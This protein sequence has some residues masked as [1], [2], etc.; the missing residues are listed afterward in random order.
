MWYQYTSTTKHMQKTLDFMKDVSSGG[1]MGTLFIIE[2]TQGN[3][4]DLDGLTYFPEESEAILAMLSRFRV[5]SRIVR[6]DMNV[7]LFSLLEIPMT[8]VIVPFST[9]VT[10]SSQ[11]A[12]EIALAQL[13]DRIQ[14]LE[15][16][17]N[18]ELERVRQEKDHVIAEKDNEIAQVIAEKDHIIA[19]TIAEKEAEKEAAVARAVQEAVEKEKKVASEREKRL[20]EEADARMAQLLQSMEDKASISPP[21]PPP[22]VK[23]SQEEAKKESEKEAAVPMTLHYPGHYQQKHWY[24]GHGW[25]CCGNIDRDNEGCQAGAVR[26]HP[27]DH[28]YSVDWNH[29]IYEPPWEWGCC[30][31]VDSGAQMV[32]THNNFSSEAK[33]E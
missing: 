18:V 22:T 24:Y 16:E 9:P 20:Q 27:R 8:E 25:V 2:L 6:A 32:L 21:T 1:L 28:N 33:I 13:Q 30:R 10:D 14:A 7:I 4:R 3:A 12:A 29:G 23:H 11:G 31:N 5:I 19:A 26:H 17:K 15:T